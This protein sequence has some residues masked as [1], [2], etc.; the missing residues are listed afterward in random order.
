MIAVNK[1]ITYKEY[2]FP[3]QRLIMLKGKILFIK[4]KRSWERW[5]VLKGPKEKS[6]RRRDFSCFLKR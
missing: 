6:R 1:I 4:N 2:A 5:K 3:G